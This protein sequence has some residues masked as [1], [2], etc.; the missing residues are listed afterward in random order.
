MNSLAN[1]FQDSRIIPLDSVGGVL[2][3][4]HLTVPVDIPEIHVVHTACLRSFEGHLMPPLGT[5]YLA[6]GQALPLKL[7]L[8][9]TRQWGP[10]GRNEEELD[11]CYEIQASSDTWLVGG[12]RSARFSAKV[13]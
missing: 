5:P 9:H 2:P 10:E 7:I 1:R 11:F 6:V 12:Q 13:S 4:Q 8:E 3:V